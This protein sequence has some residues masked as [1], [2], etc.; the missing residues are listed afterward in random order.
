MCVYLWNCI[1]QTQKNGGG[2]DEIDWY[3]SRIDFFLYIP[4]DAFYKMLKNLKTEGK[5][6]FRCFCPATYTVI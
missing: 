4:E 1:L 5:N 6:G 3:L 2:W